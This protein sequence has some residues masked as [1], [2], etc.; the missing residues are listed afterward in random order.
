MVPRTL[1][2]LCLCLC[3]PNKSAAAAL[4][5]DKHEGEL[6]NMGC[7]GDW[8]WLR[9]RESSLLTPPS[10]TAL[11]RDRVWFPLSLEEPWGFAV[12]CRDHSQVWLGWEGSAVLEFWA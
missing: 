1:L 9:L 3:A 8:G 7:N 4:Q 2:A 6:W 5:E 11:S 12:D 10:T